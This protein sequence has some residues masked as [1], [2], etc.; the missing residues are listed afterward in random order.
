M[1]DFSSLLKTKHSKRKNDTHVEQVY[2]QAK[3][4]SAD[5]SL[6]D[7]QLLNIKEL[8]EK[9]SKNKI[10]TNLLDLWGM[11][12]MK[13]Y[14]DALSGNTINP[15]FL[16]NQKLLPIKDL[17]DYMNLLDEARILNLIDIKFIKSFG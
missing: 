5:I 12:E 7:L 4:S 17:P 16:T 2:K 10:D 14:V 6:E 13:S 15:Y 9:N 3:N 8:E 1:G 11:L